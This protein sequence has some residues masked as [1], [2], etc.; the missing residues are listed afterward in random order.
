MDDLAGNN[1]E[2][3]VK[4]RY[5]LLSSYLNYSDARLAAQRI[6]NNEALPEDTSTAFSYLGMDQTAQKEYWNGTITADDIYNDISAMEEQAATDLESALLTQ[7]NEESGT[8]LDLRTFRIWRLFS[9]K[10][11]D[12]FDNAVKDY[13]YAGYYYDKDRNRI[14]FN[15][16]LVDGSIVSRYKAE[17]KMLE[18][19]GE[20]SVYNEQ[21][22]K[23]Y[24]LASIMSIYKNDPENLLKF[25]EQTGETA[26]ANYLNSDNEFKGLQAR[27]DAGEKDVLAGY[28]WNKR[29]G[30]GY[31][32]GYYNANNEQ[33]KENLE[34]LLGGEVPDL[35]NNPTLEAYFKSIF[36]DYEDYRYT[37][38]NN[39]SLT[40]AQLR[41]IRQ[42]I[43]Y[44]Q[45]AEAEKRGEVTAGTAE[46]VKTV[47]GTDEE[48]ALNAVFGYARNMSELADAE[49]YLKRY[50]AD[51]EDYSARSNL[52]SYLGVDETRLKTATDDEIDEWFE[53]KKKRVNTALSD[54]MKQT[55][56]VDSFL[57]FESLE[58]QVSA[59]K[60]E[61]YNLVVSVFDMLGLAIDAGGD[62]VKD[63]TFDL[64]EELNKIDGSEKRRT[65]SN[66]QKLYEFALNPPE[67]E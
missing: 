17:Q 11:R 9:G 12:W 62:I 47:Y 49:T 36:P 53:D 1:E 32:S 8:N 59:D 20:N 15:E 35:S 50:K 30:G 33:V 10:T 38:A 63:K 55:F 13:N 52:A 43:E 14:G 66:L 37:F 58:G 51:R 45:A 6:K 60:Q 67:V 40:P 2:K 48:A 56:D 61:L 4:A 5:T 39:G 42:Q 25:F 64:G 3:R 22:E 23:A 24:R 65:E 21:L 57:N 28:F 34:M 54:F 44:T 16:S 41:D 7:F 29:Y 46:N 18:A 31:K 26:F 27:I 19:T